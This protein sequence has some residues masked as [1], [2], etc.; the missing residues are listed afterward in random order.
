M[1]SLELQS[2]RGDQ[3]SHLGPCPEL[4][5]RGTKLYCGDSA[6]PSLIHDGGTWDVVAR[7]RSFTRLH[8]HQPVELVLVNP[9]MNK[10][11]AMGPYPAMRIIDGSIYAGELADSLLL[12]LD[13]QRDQWFYY[14]EEL[15][16]HLIRIRSAE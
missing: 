2:W 8:F 10:Q 13:D 15:Y 7:K 6:E 9:E 12:K 4:L 3:F 5:M 1:L 14:A 16:Y 11:L